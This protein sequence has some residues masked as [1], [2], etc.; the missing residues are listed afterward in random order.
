MRKTVL[1]GLLTCWAVIATATTP[2]PDAES[3]RLASYLAFIT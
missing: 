2:L 3:I 1:I